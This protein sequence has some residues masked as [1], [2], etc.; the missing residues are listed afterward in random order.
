MAYRSVCCL[1]IAA[2]LYA[3]GTS[4]SLTNS[5]NS[6]KAQPTKGS[7]PESL[8]G[9]W[10]GVEGAVLAYTF[11]K[12]GTF[13]SHGAMQT[14]LGGCTT[15]YFSSIKG[16]AIV[17]E[18]NINFKEV[19]GTTRIDDR[20]DDSDGQEE[21]ANLSNKTVVWSIEHT[22]SGEVLHLGDIKNLQRK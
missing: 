10:Q 22:P 14:E 13:T 3:C 9:T 5:T 21:E 12:D 16:I 17:R 20:C 7:I 4:P 6:V 2:S 18:Q 11:N 19:D 1:L 15:N 8:I